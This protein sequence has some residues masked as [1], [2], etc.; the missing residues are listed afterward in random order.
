MRFLFEIVSP[1]KPTLHI[2]IL[3]DFKSFKIVIVY[4]F[5]VGVHTMQLVL[6]NLHLYN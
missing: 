1:L 2:I 6:Y 3:K 4:L 5:K